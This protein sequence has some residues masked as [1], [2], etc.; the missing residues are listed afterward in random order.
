MKQIKDLSWNI[1]DLKIK[2]P[3]V[4]GG[5]GIGVSSAGLAAAVSNEGGVGTISAVGLKYLSD[6]KKM[7]SATALQNEIAKARAL[8]PEGVLAV[9]IMFALTEFEPIV[10]AA[11]DAGADIIFA[12]AGLPLDLPKMRKEDTKTK[13]VPIVSS[14]KA[15]RI[16]AKWWTE[17]YNYVPD[18]FIVEG[19][20]AGGHLGFKLNE[21]D[22]PRFCLENLITETVEVVKEL[23]QKH[24]KII[25]VIAAGGVFT[26]AD[27]N[28]FLSLG[29]T[30]VQMGTRFVATEECDAS[31]KFKQSYINCKKEDIVIMVSPV[32][33]PGRSIKNEFIDKVEQ[34]LMK[35]QV[36]S[37]HCIKT[38]KKKEAPY[39]ISKALLNAYK[40][41]LSDGF[42][43]VGANGYR[44][45]EIISV[46]TLINQL[47]TEMYL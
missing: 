47:I 44:I 31:P 11:M 15:A 3:I 28:K 10:E 8:A 46:K 5:M 33:M 25:P 17:K 12:G 22:D 21:I 43:F 32:G 29:A 18:A 36:C 4:Q 42:T 13:L 41:N 37:F 35:P 2:L 14:A 27:I 30:A 19:P 9:N 1:G 34:G 24:N 16:I 6:D 7:T 26:G 23:E 38:C 39:C 20:M 45:N 40:G